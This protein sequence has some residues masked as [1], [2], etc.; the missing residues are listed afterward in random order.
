MHILKRWS[1]RAGAL[2]KN[3]YA[4][5]LAVR[6]PRVPRSAK[7]AIAGIVAYAL[8]PIDLIPDFIPVLGLLDELILLPVAISLAIKMIP[9][10]VWDDCHARAIA[11]IDNELPHSRA[12]FWA[13]IAI[14]VIAAALIAYCGWRWLVD[15]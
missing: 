3:T 4:L 13:I 8:S 9:G 5:Y 11:A 14:W 10:E 6:D 12:A 7:L 1:V 2:K 15:S